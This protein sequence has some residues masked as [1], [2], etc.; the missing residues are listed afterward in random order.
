MGASVVLV[1]LWWFL[2][3][4]PRN[5]DYNDAAAQA[6]AAQAQ[7]DQ[8]QAQYNRLYSIKQQ[9]PRLQASLAKMQVAI[10]DKPQLDQI[11]LAINGAAN[12]SGVEVDA[13]TPTP[14]TASGGANAAPPSIRVSLSVK[15]GYNEL[16]DFM[17]RLDALP[18][19]VVIDSVN[20]SGTSGGGSVGSAEL[21]VSMSL[22]LFVT[23]APPA[24]GSTTTTTAP[25]GGTTTTTT[26]GATTTTTPGATPTTTGSVTGG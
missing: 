12:Q 2:L 24:A 9:I 14:P 8:L 13:I 23:T 22:R 11:I 25:A 20:M 10:P 6:Q 19:I 7:V 5:K 17:D 1:L 21:T 16:L 15:A 4:S 3:W 18:R 26:P